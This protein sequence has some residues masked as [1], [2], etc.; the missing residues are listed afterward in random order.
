MQIKVGDFVG[1]R[2]SAVPHDTCSK[3][4][5]HPSEPRARWFILVEIKTIRIYIGM[6]IKVPNLYAMN[7]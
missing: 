2:I 7:K 4:T 6:F 1:V 3:P 5:L